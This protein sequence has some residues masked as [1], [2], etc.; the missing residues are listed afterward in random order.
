MKV[1]LFQKEAYPIMISESNSDGQSS[2]VMSYI[3]INKYENEKSYPSH[4]QTSQFTN[5]PVD[6]TVTNNK[7]SIRNRKIVEV[8]YNIPYDGMDAIERIGLKW[9]LPRL[10][11]KIPGYHIA[12]TPNLVNA[13]IREMVMIIPQVDKK[14]TQFQYCKF[15]TEVNNKINSFDINY[16]DVK[17]AEYNAGNKPSLVDFSI[18][19]PDDI[20]TCKVNIPFFNE[21]SPFPLMYHP[22]GIEIKFKFMLDF[23]DL[24]RAKST[25][26]N[27]T[28]PKYGPV[29]LE[30]IY[31]VDMLKK[32]SSIDIPELKVQGRKFDSNGGYLEYYQKE[33]FRNS[34][35][36]ELTNKVEIEYYDYHVIS[37]KNEVRN[38]VKEIDLIGDKE[39]EG[40]EIV[41]LSWMAENLQSSMINNHCNYTNNYLDIKQGN[42]IIQSHDICIGNNTIYLSNDMFPWLYEGKTKCYP[43]VKGYYKYFMGIDEKSIDKQPGIVLDNTLKKFKLR[44]NLGKA[45]NNIIENPFTSDTSM[46]S[47]DKSSDTGIYAVH[48]ILKYKRKLTYYYSEDTNSVKFELD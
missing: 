44:L 21:K 23:I 13:M 43:R 31:C 33:C 18:E 7:I 9:K 15:E 25:T 45:D 16:V 41:E 48:V 10:R 28:E 42:D 40:R 47:I 39:L 12:W 19:L 11:S 26:E 2:P 34:E 22:G 35:T 24:I 1:S 29:T 20:I 5:K 8:S 17:E 4:F 36:K 37:T 32:Q 14:G 3:F 6:S 46:S 27:Q 38:R 30:N